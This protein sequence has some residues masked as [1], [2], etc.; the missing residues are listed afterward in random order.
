M[1]TEHS[2]KL[3]NGLRE[4]KILHTVSICEISS[5]SVRLANSEFLYA[6]FLQSTAHPVRKMPY[7]QMFPEG[8]LW[9]R[10]CIGHQGGYKLASPS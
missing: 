5:L 2:P 8:I 4:L 7:Q 10:H 3:T 6:E 1:T 9:A